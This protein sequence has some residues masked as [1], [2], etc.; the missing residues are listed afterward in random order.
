MYCF[1]IAALKVTA[2]F[3]PAIVYAFVSFCC[4]A[5]T[6]QCVPTVKRGEHPEFSVKYV[7]ILQFMYLWNRL[8]LF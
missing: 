3:V 6:Y 7:T 5:Y 8:S 1:V 2:G 4:R